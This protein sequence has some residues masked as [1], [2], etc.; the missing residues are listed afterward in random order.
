MSDSENN[1]ALD[2]YSNGWAKGDSEII[3]EIVDDSYTFSGLPNMDPIDKANFKPFWVEFRSN[4][5][6]AGGPESIS[7]EFMIFKN[8]IRRKVLSN[9]IFFGTFIIKCMYL[10]T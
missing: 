5:E 7:N 10:H 8:V 6:K 9:M 4:V 3:C 1:K 2:I